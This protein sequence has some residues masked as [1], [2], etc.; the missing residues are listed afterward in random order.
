[1]TNKELKDYGYNPQ[2]CK[3]GTLYFKDNFFVILKSDGSVD[4][5][6]RE[7]DMN[8]RETVKFI[9]ELKKLEK[10]YYIDKA[11]HYRNLEKLYSSIAD[12]YGD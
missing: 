2:I 3:I 12:N 11:E 8:S 7:D 1:M 6:S 4:F 5:H 10:Q 9:T